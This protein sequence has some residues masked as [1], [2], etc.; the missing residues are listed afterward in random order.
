MSKNPIVRRAK[1][2]RR[3]L[4]D[5][6]ARILLTYGAGGIASDPEIKAACQRML[7]EREALTLTIREA[8][9]ADKAVA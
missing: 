3:M 1:V 6:L 9:A 2:A 7:T 5:K 8:R 4:D